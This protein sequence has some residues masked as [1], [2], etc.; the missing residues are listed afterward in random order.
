MANIN[1]FTP[2][3]I[4]G[5]TA[6]FLTSTNAQN[7]STIKSYIAS[8]VPTGKTQVVLGLSWSATNQLNTC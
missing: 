7:T 2:Q 3:S 6:T 8:P 4:Y 5:R 1:L